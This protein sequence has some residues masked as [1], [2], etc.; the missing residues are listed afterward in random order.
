[1]LKILVL[2]TLSL[3]LK[4]AQAQTLEP[5]KNFI[6]KNKTYYPEQTREFIIQRLENCDNAHSFIRSFIPFY[7]FRFNE[8]A[9]NFRNYQSLKSFKG[10]VLGDAHIE[11]F[12]FLTT[13]K[14]KLLFGFND[15]DDVAKAPYIT[16][17]YRHYV[18]TKLSNIEISINDYIKIYELGLNEKK[19]AYGSYFNQLKNEAT[20]DIGKLSKKYVDSEAKK[21]KAFLGS[22]N[23]VSLLTS[24]E[25]VKITKLLKAQ[26]GREFQV[27][28]SYRYYKT[29]GGSA[30]MDRIE[31][32]LTSNNKLEWIE[33]KEQQASGLKTLSDS[34]I[35]SDSIKIEHI[36]KIFFDKQLSNSFKLL[37]YNS[38][39]YLLRFR[40]SSNK[41]IELSEVSSK[42]REVL[43]YD[44]VYTLGRIHALSLKNPVKTSLTNSLDDIDLK[45][46]EK[47]TKL[48]I[49]QM[50]LDFEKA[51]E[52]I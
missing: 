22:K 13:D 14:N 51:K 5:I 39:V 1:M 6:T 9:N 43:I 23:E 17:L 46:F 45:Q 3:S 44:E 30:S 26:L 35:L 28:D 2:V 11:N 21:F 15:L 48:I 33:L 41:G 34:D 42:E 37:R 8:L 49:N 40:K 36:N 20:D 31:I 19:Y 4:L 7:Y 10:L 24:T 25:I 38:K 27:L 12:G 16:D 32:L 50:K 18:S 29:T 52:E 47:E